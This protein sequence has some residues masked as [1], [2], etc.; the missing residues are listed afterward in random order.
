MFKTT[1]KEIMEEVYPLDEIE[2]EN[3]FNLKLKISLYLERSI[4][5][6]CQSNKNKSHGKKEVKN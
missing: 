6:Y 5:S 2:K 1:L 4:K 3:E